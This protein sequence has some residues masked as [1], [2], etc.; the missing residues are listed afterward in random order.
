VGRD[1]GGRG[2]LFPKRDEQLAAAASPRR[3]WW[4][5]ALVV[6]AASLWAT[7][8]LFARSLYASGYSPLE[9]ASVRA[10][11]GLL[12]CAPFAL[13]HPSR[14]R[15]GARDVAF[16]AVYGVVGFALFE[17]LYFV[18]I[19]HTT[20]A[21]A[22]ALLYTAP[23]FVVLLSRLLW[24]EHVGRT[25]LGALVLVL[26]GVVLVTGAV[27]AV[28]TGQA[29]VGVAALL[30]GL[31]SGFTYALYTIFSKVALAKTDPVSA[32]FWSFGFAALALAFAAPPIPPL[33]RDTADLPRLL[34][35]GIV[36]TLLAYFLYLRALRT[37]AASTASM[38]AAVE[39]AVA[40]LLA[41]VVFREHVSLEQIPGIVLIVIAAVMLAAGAQPSEH[42]A[43]ITQ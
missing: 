23:A 9:L 42:A 2:E 30:L 38:L 6:A 19:A 32:L 43:S 16:F 4:A 15:L 33:L 28:V 27:R 29:T 39:P 37:L 40:T 25:R 34:A 5:A 31:G 12:G 24:Q 1:R 20:I 7:F 11:I 41:A 13:G 36:P 35:L 26:I 21:V 22:A 18:T 14:L 10:F 8:G 3:G 17:W